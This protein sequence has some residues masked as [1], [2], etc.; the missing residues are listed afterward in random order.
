M[1]S[2]TFLPTN[3]STTLTV[4]KPSETPTHYLANSKNDS[5][6][7]SQTMTTRNCWTPPHKTN[8]NCPT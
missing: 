2:L 3:V 6:L 1:T 8:C 4:N 7:L 5:Q